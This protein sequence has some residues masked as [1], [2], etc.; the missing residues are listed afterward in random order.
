MTIDRNVFHSAKPI[1]GCFGI[2]NEVSTSHTIPSWIALI[3]FDTVVFL[4]TV[5]RVKSI[6]RAKNDQSL[7]LHILFRD[8]KRAT[9]LP[10]RMLSLI[11]RH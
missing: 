5:I 8:G 7:L 2:L 4:L 6:R 9:V 11:S 1:L 10:S 3:V